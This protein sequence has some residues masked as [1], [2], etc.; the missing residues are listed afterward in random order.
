[1]IHIATDGLTL[2]ACECVVRSRYHR[3]PP[4]TRSVYWCIIWPKKAYTPP[5]KMEQSYP[6]NSDVEVVLWIN[7]YVSRHS[8]IVQPGS[9]PELH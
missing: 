4:G 1:M 8:N 9:R 2:G 6:W 5:I 7:G 3:T